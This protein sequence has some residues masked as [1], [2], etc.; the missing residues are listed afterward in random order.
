M[1]D[2]GLKSYAAC[3]SS[4]SVEWFTP[5]EIIE[6]VLKLYQGEITTDP[7]A[8]MHNDP[9]LPVSYSYTK[10]ENGL[11]WPWKG[12]VYLNPPYSGRVL[13]W[14]DKAVK[15][16]RAGNIQEI[17]ILWKSSTDTQAFRKITEI[18]DH[19]CFISG[20]LKFSGSKNPAP[21][22]SAL[23]YAGHHKDAF[24]DLFSEFGPIWQKGIDRRPP[25]AIIDKEGITITIE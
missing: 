4:A 3:H 23:F 20:R 19:V 6:A 22:P 24:R 8:R 12:K 15:E 2:S 17:L 1:K 21:F 9:A 11:S 14:M 25:A 7:A 18:A 16:Y 13:L 10:E 5:P